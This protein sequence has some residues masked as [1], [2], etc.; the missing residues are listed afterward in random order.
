[1]DIPGHGKLRP[2]ALGRVHGDAMKKERVKGVVFVVDSTEV[3]GAGGYLHD[4]LLAMQRAPGRKRVLVAANKGDLFTA[5]PA[6]G[7]RRELEGE[8]G[9]VRESRSRGLLDSGGE[10]E[11]VDGWVGEYGSDKFEF[12]QMEEFG[13]EVDV[14]G[15]S[16]LDGRADAWWEWITD[17]VTA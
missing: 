3:G 12:G 13:V 8:I 10:E 4:V 16:V 14:V 11:D 5:M 9:R 17:S 15:G 1:M 2:D 7:V 6:E